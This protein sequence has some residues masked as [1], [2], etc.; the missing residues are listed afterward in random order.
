MVQLFLEH[1]FAGAEVFL[2][3]ML[4]YDHYGAICKPL[5]YFIIINR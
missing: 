3:V 1:L 2:L 5:Q 4:A